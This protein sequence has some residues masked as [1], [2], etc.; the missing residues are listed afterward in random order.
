MKYD[1]I[2]FYEDE[3][4]KEIESVRNDHKK[5][6]KSKDTFGIKFSKV[7]K[8]DP[9]CRVFH[10]G[11]HKKVFAYSVNTACDENNFVL[12]FEVTAGN[13]HDS[14]V[15]PKLYD[16]LKRKYSD[17][18]R[19]VVDAGYKIPAIAKIIIDIQVMPYKRPMTKD[20]AYSQI[21]LYEFKKIS[22]LEMER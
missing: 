15:F 5:T 18:K 8:T 21:C 22:N 19:V 1:W 9:E 11:E 14:V 4:Q 16:S 10:K 7:S 6:L 3:L 17:F 20:G 13:I 12:D 2:K